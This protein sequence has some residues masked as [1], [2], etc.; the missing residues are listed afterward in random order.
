MLS[1]FIRKNQNSKRNSK[2]GK[3]FLGVVPQ[4]S[5]GYPSQSL[6]LKQDD[7]V[8]I[9][10]R[11][12]WEEIQ[13]ILNDLLITWVKCYGIS[14]IVL[15][16]HLF[17]GHLVHFLK[18]KKMIPKDVNQEGFEAAHSFTNRALERKTSNEAGWHRTPSHKQVLLLHLRKFY[19][20][21]GLIPPQE[22]KARV[23]LNAK[24]KTRVPTV[25]INVE[26][27]DVDDLA[28]FYEAL[29]TDE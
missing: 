18:T 1:L 9:Q 14:T 12:G 3:S 8:R 26:G 19:F 7:L 17:H 24:P 6:D 29:F 20:E 11:N 2:N 4:I 23:K 21:T 22:I 5:M 10:E 28:E 27:G 15:Y 13:E 16:L 25:G